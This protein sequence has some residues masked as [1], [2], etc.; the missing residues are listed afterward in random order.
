MPTQRIA[1]R[2]YHRGNLLLV[3]GGAEVRAEE[4]EKG[5]GTK[6]GTFIQL[7]YYE[8]DHSSVA[9]ASKA[10]SLTLFDTA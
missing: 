4:R 1:G 5:E 3:A 7:Q 6:K 10:A 2:A 9:A 8:I